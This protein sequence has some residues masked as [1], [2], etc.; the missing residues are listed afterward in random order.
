LELTKERHATKEVPMCKHLDRISVALSAAVLLG[1]ATVTSEPA[2]ASSNNSSAQRTIV[3]YKTVP[4]IV[5]YKTV[6]ATS[7]SGG[8]NTASSSSGNSGGSVG[9]I[10]KQVLGDFAKTAIDGLLKPPSK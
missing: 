6:S 3:V 9:D 7:K 1:A 8:T 2:K 5:L 10:F 4:A